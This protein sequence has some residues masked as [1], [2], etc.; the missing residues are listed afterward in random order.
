MKEKWKLDIFT[1]ISIVKRIPNVS[2]PLSVSMANVLDIIAL[3]KT[4]VHQ[5]SQFVT[6]LSTLLEGG[7]I[8]EI[9]LMITI[10]KMERRAI[11]I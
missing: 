4:I 7:D 11:P 6:L 10:V 5:H 2:R 3:S 8:V 1:N 9:V